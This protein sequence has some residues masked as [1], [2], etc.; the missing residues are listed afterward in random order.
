MPVL[1]YPGVRPNVRQAPRTWETFD[2]T[3][4]ARQ[5]QGATMADSRRGHKDLCRADNLAWLSVIRAFDGSFIHLGNLLVPGCPFLQEHIH[6]QPIEFRQFDSLEPATAGLSLKRLGQVVPNQIMAVDNPVDLVQRPR[7][8]LSQS[9]PQRRQL[10]V[11]T[12][13]LRQHQENR[14]SRLRRLFHRIT[15]EQPRL[16][17]SLGFLERG[18]RQHFDDSR[19]IHG[20]RLRARGRPDTSGFG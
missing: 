9:L 1:R 4:T 17:A 16:M 11:F 10:T 3:D 19:G 13:S 6:F 8:T 15:P 18:S 7:S 14:L 12:F 2:G 5:H 20:P